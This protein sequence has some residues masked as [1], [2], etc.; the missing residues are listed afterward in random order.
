MK[1]NDI[2]VLVIEKYYN[3]IYRYCYV[4]LNFDEY[5]AQDCAQE[6]FLA[7]LQKKKRLDLNVNIRAWLYKTAALTIK[8][9]W[10]KQ[11]KLKNQ[12]SIDDMELSDN[13]GL[14]ILNDLDLLDC[15]PEEDKELLLSYYDAEYGHRNELAQKYNMTLYQLYKEI[16]R[17]KQKIKSSQET[18]RRS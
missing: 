16:N 3:E 18:E 12:I 6:I 14:D 8:H 5:A 15:L 2:F 13:G 7:L 11:K 1:Q 17:I 9:Y 4:K 10:R